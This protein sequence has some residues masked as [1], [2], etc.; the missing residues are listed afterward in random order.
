MAIVQGKYT[1]QFG[2]TADT[3]TL[4]DSSRNENAAPTDQDL[5]V[6]LLSGKYAGQSLYF[7]F[8]NIL[9]IKRAKIDAVG[10]PG[11]QRPYTPGSGA[12]A[13]LKFNLIANNGNDDPMGGFGLL[14]PNWGEWYEIDTPVKPF[15]VP[16][17]PVWNM[18]GGIKPYKLNMSSF[19]TIYYDGFNLAAEYVGQEFRPVITLELET[20]GVYNTAMILI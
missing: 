15:D 1:V 16:V 6:N 5:T 12:A 7:E 20:P 9:L 2:I 14:F 3:F 10:A 17:A 13:D 4:S 8:N 11:L 18:P 19:S